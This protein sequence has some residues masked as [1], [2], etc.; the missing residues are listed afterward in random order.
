MKNFTDDRKS[1][2]EVE[3]FTERLPLPLTLATFAKDDHHTCL[4]NIYVTYK[5]AYRLTPNPSSILEYILQ[6]IL[7][8]LVP[9]SIMA[10]SANSCQL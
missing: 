4:I 9:C 6:N 2:T 3:F 7:T 10:R 8:H 1:Y 5:N